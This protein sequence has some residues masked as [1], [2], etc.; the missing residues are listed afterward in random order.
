M[1]NK[2][3]W[4]IAGQGAIGSLCCAYGIKS[5]LEMIPIVKKT[6]PESP[7]EFVGAQQSIK[8][9]K[10][11][12][13]EQ[14]SE[15]INQLLV[16]LKAYD[17]IPFLTNI[18]P[19]LAD[20]VHIILC[21][22]GLGVVEKVLPLL[23]PHSQLYVCT[24]NNGVYK[25]GNKII[26][27]GTGNTFWKQIEHQPS[28]GISAET[29]T[30]KHIQPLNNELFQ[31]LFPQAEMAEDLNAILW[32]KLLINAVINPLTA[33]YKVKNGALSKPKFHTE[34]NG[35]I[36]EVETLINALNINLGTISATKLVYSVIEQTAEN[37]SS[38]QQDVNA[39]KRTEIDYINGYIVQQA[40]ALGLEARKNQQLVEQIHQLEHDFS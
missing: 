23:P 14:V 19:Q 16:P 22:N 12:T 28:S 2:Q 1:L 8:L 9:P 24:T 34:V 6:P 36:N 13:L 11:Q 29:K 15:K 30:N 17:I 32:R 26:Q 5:G 25:Q 3:P 35:I 33:I 20:D 21:H 7:I 27:A 18:K 38:M 40:M 39:H 4:Y 37:T 10:G 31:R